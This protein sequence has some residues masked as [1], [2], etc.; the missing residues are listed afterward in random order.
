MNY[1]FKEEKN[2][3]ILTHSENRGRRNSSQIILNDQYNLFTKNL[4]L[5]ENYRSIFHKS[6]EKNLNK[7]MPSR[8]QLH[9][10]RKIHHDHKGL[11]LGMQ[12]CI[13]Q[14]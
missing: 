2:A 3:F 12:G 11:M 10:K 9:T 5:Q 7:V 8:I 4:T 1:I 14:N 13:I 6:K